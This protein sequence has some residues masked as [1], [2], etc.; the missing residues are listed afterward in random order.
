MLSA[1][2]CKRVH[3]SRTFAGVLGHVHAELDDVSGEDLAGRALLG[4]AAQALAVDEGSIA[5]LGVLEIELQTEESL[6][7]DCRYDQGRQRSQLSD[8]ASGTHRTDTHS[9]V[10][11]SYQ[12][13]TH[14]HT[15]ITHTHA[16]KH[17]NTAPGYLQQP[18]KN[19]Q[20][21]IHTLERCTTAHRI[22][23]TLHGNHTDLKSPPIH[24]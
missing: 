20:A 3:R 7:L 10:M 18:I 8:A 21:H 16:N 17:K 24:I 14:M 12:P 15:S 13:N 19:T 2:V 11:C 6:P 1:L 5:A 4:P 9:S 23:I 22:T